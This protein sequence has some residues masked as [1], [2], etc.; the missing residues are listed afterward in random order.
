[1]KVLLE[2]T[3]FLSIFQSSYDI[4]YNVERSIID[5]NPLSPA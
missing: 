2:P 5:R 3:G 4:H 1:M